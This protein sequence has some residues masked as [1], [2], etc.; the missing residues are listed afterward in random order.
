MNGCKSLS[1]HAC[2]NNSS[3]PLSAHFPLSIPTTI[4]MAFFSEV[5]VVV[6]WDPM[7]SSPPDS[8]VHG[9]FQMRILE[10]VPISFSR[11][12][13]HPRDQTSISCTDRQIFYHWA[14]RS[15]LQFKQLCFLC[16]YLRLGIISCSWKFS[17]DLHG[18][19]HCE[20]INQWLIFFSIAFKS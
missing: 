5:V 2:L 7:D 16:H 4:Y 17:N 6:V 18:M 15:V 8:S 19:L 12:S 9:I 20:I 1:V 10:W 11:E 14:T 3:L 13:S